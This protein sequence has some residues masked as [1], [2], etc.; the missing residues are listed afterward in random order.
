MSR[1]MLELKE[2]A[3]LKDG[4]VIT[5]YGYYRI[6][7]GGGADYRITRSAEP[8]DGGSVVGLQNGLQAHLLPPSAIRYRMF[9]AVG[10]GE[11]DDGVQI[12]L[13]HSYANRNGIPID[14]PAGEFWIKDTTQIPIRTNVQW[15][16]TKLHIDEAFNRTDAYRFIVPSGRD[17]I[18]PRFDPAQKAS[19]VSK[20]KPG[21][22]EIAELAPYKNSLVVVKDENDRIGIRQGYE[23]NRGWPRTEFF[24]VEEYGR[25]IGDMAWTFRDYTSLTVY[26]CDES[27]LT[28]E[29]GTIFL[30]GNDPGSDPNRYVHNG[31]DVRRSRTRIVNQWVGLEPGRADTS[32]QSR[33]G[34]YN[35]S[36]VYDV[37]LE[38]IRLIPWEYFRSDPAKRVAHGTYGLGGNTVMNATYRNITAEGTSIHWGVFGTNLYKNFRVEGCRLNRIDV[39]FHCWNLYVKDT[40][41]GIRGFTLTGGG[42]LTIENTKVTGNGFV[43]MRG[44]Y[45][46]KW[47]GDIRIR[48]CRLSVTGTANAHAISFDSRDFDYKYPIVYGRTIRIEDF[49]FDFTADPGARAVCTLIKI[50][51]FSKTKDGTRIGFPHAVECRNVGVEGRDSGVRIMRIADA[52]GFI[53]RRRGGFDGELMKPNCSMRFVN[54]QLESISA[55][56]ANTGNEAHFV[57]QGAPSAE[58]QGGNGLYA[59]IEFADCRPFVGRF[60]E[61]VADIRFSHCLIRSIRASEDG[62]ETMNGKL[63]FDRCHFQADA[64]DDGTDFNTFG[65]SLGTTFT[66]CTI[67]TPIV[68]GAARPDHVNRYALFRYNESVA[69]NHTNTKLAKRIVDDYARRGIV[70][71]PEFAA[72]LRSSS[73]SI[74]R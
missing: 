16:Q 22:T 71:K 14:N 19:I 42:D 44:D 68:D 11:N 55:Q 70:P 74:W 38:N 54:I 56:A 35:F 60:P 10:D 36:C 64:A 20:L 7:D 29:G 43:S 1:T 49:V 51:D 62:G 67:N 26:P 39:H 45:G 34:F 3:Q 73:D 41:I 63:S 32:S 28:I 12:K 21:T 13:A 4:D 72:W 6:G 46:G 53:V 61:A 66:N 58:Q 37:L 47:D 24:Y 15:G 50:P 5:T 52:S 40:E 8:E 30:T 9:G 69:F 2:A 23:G 59:S 27:Y 25:I 57:L 48:G 17:P 18:A 65:T 31:F 33:S